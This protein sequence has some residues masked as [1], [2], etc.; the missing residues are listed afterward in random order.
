MSQFGYV[1]EIIS[2][3]LYNFI[4]TYVKPSLETAHNNAE[5]RRSQDPGNLEF[6]CATMKNMNQIQEELSAA[7]NL[8]IIKYCDWI[9]LTINEILEDNYPKAKYWKSTQVENK[10][11][12]FYH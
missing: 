4:K 1:K 9:K 12:L 11:N 7:R 10:Q 2:S 6:I 8:N 5:Q 3:T